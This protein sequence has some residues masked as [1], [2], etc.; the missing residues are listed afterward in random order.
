MQ[1]IKFLKKNVLK[2]LP[3]IWIIRW[4]L[5]S[6]SIL[7]LP[8]KFLNEIDL[9]LISFEPEYGHESHCCEKI[10]QLVYMCMRVSFLWNFLSSVIFFWS[11]CFSFWFCRCRLDRL[12]S[13]VELMTWVLDL[14]VSH[15]NLISP[16]WN[17]SKLFSF[18]LISSLWGFLIEML[19]LE[20]INS[21]R[22]NLL[23]IFSGDHFDY[24][25]YFHVLRSRKVISMMFSYES[26]DMLRVLQCF[27]KVNFKFVPWTREKIICFL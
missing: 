3:K 16:S 24:L 13:F 10:L 25:K 4:K 9:C 23:P 20:W 14:F 1:S 8:H 27:R 5:F 26:L 18:H 19:L 11:D 15:Q 6:R 7:Q 21:F 17:V 22:S 12:H 2:N